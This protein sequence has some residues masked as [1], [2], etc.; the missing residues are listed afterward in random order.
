VT[1]GYSGWAAGQLEN[2]IK[3]NAWLTVEARDMIIFD[4]PADER[5]PAA[6]KLLGVDFAKL[7]EEAGHA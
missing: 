1:L 3:Q 5:L 7:S 4:T 2:E 6:M